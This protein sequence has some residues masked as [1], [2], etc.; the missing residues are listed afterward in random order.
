MDDPAYVLNGRTDASIGEGVRGIR[1]DRHMTMEEFSKSLGVSQSQ[2]S[3]LENGLQGWRSAILRK[4]ARAVG[5]I[6]VEFHGGKG[7]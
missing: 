1:R 3:R 6:A 7:K 4:L 5:P 2:L